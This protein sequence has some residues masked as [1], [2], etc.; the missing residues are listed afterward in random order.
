LRLHREGIIQLPEAEKRPCSRVQKGRDRKQKAVGEGV[1]CEMSELG[2][3]RIIKVHSYPVLNVGN[4]KLIKGD[5][6]R[7]PLT[8]GSF[9]ITKAT[10][11]S[12]VRK[13]ILFLTEI[14]SR[15]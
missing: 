8:K 12:N 10:F 4:D 15:Q 14:V 7:S 5:N 3:M 6:H 1:G 2:E 11:I 9:I 13:G